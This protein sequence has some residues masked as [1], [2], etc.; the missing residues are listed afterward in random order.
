MTPEHFAVKW[1][2]AKLLVAVMTDVL[3][4]MDK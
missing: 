1:V 2:S 4:K 3:C